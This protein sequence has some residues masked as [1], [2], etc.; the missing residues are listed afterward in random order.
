M[1]VM[2]EMLGKPAHYVARPDFRVSAGACQI[3]IPAVFCPGA[4]M[5]PGYVVELALLSFTVSIDYRLGGCFLFQIF[6]LPCELYLLS[7][8]LIFLNISQFTM[9][10]SSLGKKYIMALSGLILVGFVVGHMVGN[11]QMFLHPDWI[12]EYAYKLQHLP[13]GLIWVVRL[14]LLVTVVAHIVTAVLLV[15]ENKKAR[16][17]GY[18]VNRPIQA[19]FASR[20]MRYSGLIL[21]FFIIFH[22]MHF[23]VQ[24]IH[25]EFKE[26]ETELAGVGT[27]HGVYDKLAAVGKTTVHDVH[28]MVAVGFSARY[29]Y[30]S[31]FY[32]ISMVL[33]CFHL[34]HGISSMFQSLGFRNNI[35]RK[36]LDRAAVVIAWAVFIGFASIPA[37]GLLGKL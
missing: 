26:L 14:V 29:W 37:V 31:L 6:P 12:N 27:I 33:L 25:P 13:Y 2:A 16:P 1:D 35:W 34:S 3:T 10:M 7:Q 28:T 17:Q 15:I 30:V 23:T 20:T 4:R 19:T 32:I 11:L 18:S 24:N 5:A 22:I 21:I 8:G 9:K 36:R